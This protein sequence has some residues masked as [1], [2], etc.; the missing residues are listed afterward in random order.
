MCSISKSTKKPSDDDICYHGCRR[1]ALANIFED[2]DV[3]ALFNLRLLNDCCRRREECECCPGKS[4]HSLFDEK[5]IFT[6]AR[7]SVDAGNHVRTTLS[8]S[9]ARAAGAADR[10]E[11]PRRGQL[12]SASHDLDLQVNKSSTEWPAH[13]DGAF[14]RSS[15]EMTAA[16]AS[17]RAGTRC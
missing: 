8:S 4:P 16:T 9:C 11:P 6:F 17:G 12:H 7:E 13:I 15:A 3:E 5:P 2:V 14:T 1:N 10:A